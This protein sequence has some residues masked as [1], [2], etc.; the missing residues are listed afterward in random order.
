MASLCLISDNT[1]TCTCIWNQY[2]KFFLECIDFIFFLFGQILSRALE[3][4]NLIKLGYM[5]QSWQWKFMI[6][7]TKS[8]LSNLTIKSLQQNYKQKSNWH[9]IFP[10][11]VY[12]LG[13]FLKI[14]IYLY[15]SNISHNYICFPHVQISGSVAVGGHG[16]NVYTC[17]YCQCIQWVLCLN[18]SSAANFP[19]PNDKDSGVHK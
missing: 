16:G 9:T 18:P 3:V 10:Y 5:I 11:H 12:L 2:F 4:H 17:C 8:I 1:C 19:P 6:M 14:W 7:R 13:C 15:Y